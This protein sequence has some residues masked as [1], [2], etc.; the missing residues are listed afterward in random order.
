[1]F[2][3]GFAV[4]LIPTLSWIWLSSQRFG[5]NSIEELFRFVFRLGSNDRGD[6]GLLFYLWNVPTKAF[7][8]FFFALLGLVLLLR[9]PIP[10]YQLILVGFPLVLFAEVSIFSTRLPHYS[11]ALYP[12]IALLASVGLDWLG[13]IFSKRI[14]EQVK[15]KKEK[16]KSYMKD[17]LPFSFYLLPS[18][19]SHLKLPRNL[20]YAF[21]GLSVLLLLAGIV[22]FALGGA[23]IRK[24]AIV[25]LA[26]GLGWLILPLVWIGRYH[27]GIKS[28]TGRYW[29]A[30]WLIPAWLALAVAGFNGLIGDY[31]PDVKAFLAQ[32][33]IASILQTN[34]V[35]FVQVG[36]KTGVLLNF[37]TPHHGK[38]VQQSELPAD[39]YAWISAKQAA[40]LSTPHRVLGTVQ[41]YQLIQVLP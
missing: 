23:D 27:F 34:P 13:G 35:N 28:L 12:F 39:S 7:P 38:E 14:R 22:A 8:W 20:S 4:G 37:Y 11:L 36:D 16:G 18:P 3:S 15:R 32:R 5:N 19:S 6:H 21:G 26:L 2:Y 9:R 41:K 24:Y 17:F 33:A 31:N 40:E 1:M 25:V 30:G 10:R 29:V